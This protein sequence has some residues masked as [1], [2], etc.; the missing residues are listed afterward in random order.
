MEQDLPKLPTI[1]GLPREEY[2]RRSPQGTAL[3]RWRKHLPDLIELQQR[4][5]PLCAGE[6]PED[7]AEVHV[8]HITPRSL[9]GTDDFDNLQATCGFCNMSKGNGS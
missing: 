3:K 2:Q 8:D 1:K 6:L 4:M 5:C 9:G 7:Y